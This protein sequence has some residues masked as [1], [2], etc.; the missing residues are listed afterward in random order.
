MERRN[1]IN[2]SCERSGFGKIREWTDGIISEKYQDYA[3][4][5]DAALA[6]NSTSCFDSDV[7]IKFPL[8]N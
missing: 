3:L 1:G 6:P 4:F 2:R 5:A 7:E 8:G